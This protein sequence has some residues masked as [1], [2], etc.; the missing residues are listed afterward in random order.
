MSIY[1]YI[2][3]YICRQYNWH[4]R[5]FYRENSETVVQLKGLTPSGSLPFGTLAGGSDSLQSGNDTV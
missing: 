4:C 1:I 2:Y 3:I 5:L